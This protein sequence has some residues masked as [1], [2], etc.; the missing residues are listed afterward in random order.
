MSAPDFRESFPILEDATGE[1]V[2]LSKSLEGDA[3][4]G[5]IAATVLTFKDS[6]GNLVHP[7]LDAAGRI[8]VT[9]SAGVPVKAR[10]EVPAGSASGTLATVAE[11]VLTA[12]KT[13]VEI[14]ALVSCRRDALFVLEQVDDAAVTVLEDVILGPGQYTFKTDLSSE[15]ITAGASGTQ[16]LRLR[17]YNLLAG[18]A[19][20]SALRGTIAA[21]RVDSV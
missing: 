8:K 14:E 10:G 6:S 2:A 12:E 11:L 7:Q 13:Y 9:P 21:K 5:K 3:A 20:L 19:G 16:K 1:G 15:E 17:A 4:S 18:A